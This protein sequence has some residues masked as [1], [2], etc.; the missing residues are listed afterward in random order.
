MRA[1]G[2]AIIIAGL[3]LLAVALLGGDAILGGNQIAFFVVLAAGVVCLGY[4]AMRQ[5]GGED[6]ETAEGRS[7]AD[8]VLFRTLSRMA[9]ADTNIG[10]AEVE[11]VQRI[12]QAASGEAVTA[13]D[14]RTAA[15]GDLYEDRPFDKYL[16]GVESRLSNDEKMRVVKAMCEVIGAD[17]RTSPFETEFFNMVTENLKLTP[18][19]LADLRAASVPSEPAPA[20]A[21]PS[22]PA[23]PAEPAGETADDGEEETPPGG[24]GPTVT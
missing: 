13:G 7:L 15:R 14:V 2:W 23:T 6:A 1:S 5:F 12:Y 20:A 11:T 24:P 4:G 17:E 3:V 22:E 18:A 9:S 16:S 8:E 19:D 21:A 10:K